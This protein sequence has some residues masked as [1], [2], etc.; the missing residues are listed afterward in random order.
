MFVFLCIISGKEGAVI[1]IDLLRI[2]PIDG[3]ILMSGKDFSSVDSHTELMQ[4]LDGRLVDVI[5]SDM[6][7]NA[8]GVKTLDHEK[9]VDLCLTV[10]KF[11]LEV[12]SPGGTVLCK[13]WQGRKLEML[14]S[15]F[16]KA[17]DSVKVIKPQASRS[18][19]AEL[20]ILGR[21]FKG[22][23]NILQSR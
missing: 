10:L 13:L 20:F 14:R 12:L 8:T 6:A 3:V 23:S 22:R 9:I 11:S 17:F 5:L 16:E 2:Q 7:P 21:K 4:I 1:G 15:V 19:S 18:D